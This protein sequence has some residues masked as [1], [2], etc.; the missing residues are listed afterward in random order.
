M[1]FYQYGLFPSLVRF[2]VAFDCGSLLAKSK[3]IG[4]GY[5]VFC[6]GWSTCRLEVA[7]EPRAFQLCLEV[8]WSYVFVVCFFGFR[9]SACG[10]GGR[11]PVNRRRL[12]QWE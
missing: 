7:E 10:E 11:D 9:L 5:C 3:G 2:W 4:V 12:R 1:L 6:V 8:C